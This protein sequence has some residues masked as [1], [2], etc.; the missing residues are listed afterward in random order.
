[1]T[2]PDLPPLGA[3][4]SGALPST[5]PSSALFDGNLPSKAAIEAIMAHPR[6]TEACRSAAAGLV[7]LYQGERIINQ[8][9]PDRIRYII[10]V[11]AL[12]LH[13]AGRPNDPSSGLTASRLCKLCVERKIC[14][15]GRAEAMLAIMRSYGH[16]VPA[17]SESDRRLRRLVPAEPLFA[18][19]RKRCTFFFEAAAKVLPDNA[20]ALAALDA[21]EFMPKFIRHLAKTH[22]EGF[23]YVAYVPDVRMFFERDAGGPILMSIA[24]AGGSDDTFPPSRS[25]SVSHLAIARDF[26]VSRMHVRRVIQEGVRAELL[27]RAGPSGNELNVSPRLRDGVRRVLAAYLAHYTH[28]ARLAF[29]EIRQESAVA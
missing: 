6:F 12:H 4:P 23:H 7:A 10:S 2:A 5:L 28:C 18:W 21:P 19:H 8:V 26:G 24:L 29:A 25:I 20:D 16:L 22:A 17:P 9:M 11:F 14:S 15:T 1:M 3:L 13:F 27:E